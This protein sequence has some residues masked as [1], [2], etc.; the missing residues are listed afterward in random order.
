MIEDRKQELLIF[1][2]NPADFT[3]NRLLTLQHTIGFILSMAASRNG[4]GY[5]ITSQNYFRELGDCLGEKID[6]ACHQSISEA[7]SKLC[8][9][10]LEYLLTEANLEASRLPSSL[11]FKGHITRAIDG[12]SFFTPRSDEL[13]LHFSPRKTK[14]EEGETHYPYGLCV[15]AI[16][17]FTGQPVRAIVN[18]Y[19]ASERALLKA[20]ISGFGPGDLALLDRGLGGIQVYLEFE[21]HKQ[22]FVHRAKTGGDRVASYIQAFLASEEKQRA[23]ELTVTDDETHATGALRLRLV[24]GPNDSEGKPIV[25]VTNLLSPKH[26]PR[27]DILSLYKRRWSVETLYGRVKNLLNLEQFHARSYNGIMQE[28]FANLLILSLTAV[29]VIAVV[30][31]DEV[32][33]E[34]TLPSFKNAA[35]SIRRNLFS[36]IDHRIEGITPKK[37][38]KQILEEV[39]AVMYTI[40][41][42]R[43]YARVSMQPIKSWNL[44]KSAKLKAFAQQRKGPGV[45]RS[46][47]ERAPLR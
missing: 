34:A 14:A 35:E 38:M 45:L 25:F 42:G 13:L 26:Y 10:A 28:I 12:T 40:R 22:L 2:K 36:V 47:T 41:P 37:L 18:D 30:E 20:M 8:W 11:R 7:R 19:R 31:E 4:N 27:Q 3:R 39:R 23:V 33:I 16:N 21:R 5:D 44:K 1:R 17:V 24:R 32:D 9:R 43:S 46:K 29:A 15:A 6:P